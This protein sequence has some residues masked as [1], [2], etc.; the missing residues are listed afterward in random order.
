MREAL[1][2]EELRTAEK[3]E[4]QGEEV[5]GSL[6]P[7]E[8]VQDFRTRWDH[9]Q[10]TFVDEPRAAVKQ[11]DDLVNTAIQRLS[12]SFTMARNNLE[13]QWDRGDQ[14]NSEDLRVA[15]RKYRAFFQRILAV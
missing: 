1:Q 6:L 15:F 2:V 7:Q 12:E 8:S 11:A 3:I 14:V 13:Q 9:V 4:N 10:A 5:Q